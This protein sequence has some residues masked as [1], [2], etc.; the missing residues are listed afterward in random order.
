M[1]R[2]FGQLVDFADGVDNIALPVT[3]VAELNGPIKQCC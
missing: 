1:Q 3:T 2:I